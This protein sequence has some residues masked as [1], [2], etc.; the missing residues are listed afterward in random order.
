MATFDQAAGRRRT[1]GP[2]ARLLG[3]A[4]QTSAPLT[5]TALIMAVVLVAAAAGLL[6]DPRTI[7]GAPA[8]LKPAKFAVSIAVYAATLIWAFGYLGPWPRTRTIAGWT[9]AVTLII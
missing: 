3:R 2:A 7:T 4:W 1:G 5:A 9:T 8:W 6:V